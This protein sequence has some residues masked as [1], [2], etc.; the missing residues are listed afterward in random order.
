MMRI[1]REPADLREVLRGWRREGLSVA[2]VPTMGDLH[3]GHMALVEEARRRADRVIVSVFVNPLQFNDPADFSAYP[4]VPEADAGLLERAGVDLLF[5]PEAADVYPRGVAAG[6]RVL[7]PQIGDELCGAF[8]PGHFD[9]VATVVAILF[10]LTGPDIALFGEKDYQQ[11]LLVRRMVADLHFPI[12]IVAVPTV[13]EE[14]GLALSSRNR[15]LDAEER[16]R[17]GRLFA[18]LTAL[19]DD[20]LRGGASVAAALEQRAMEA[21]AAAG[22]RP[23][24]V[25]IRRAADLA[26]PRA[27]DR[28][29]RVLA[30]AWLGRARLIDNLSA[31]L[32]ESPVEDSIKAPA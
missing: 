4:R 27:G 19:R 17:A 24:Y 8:R 21:L 20:L 28:H 9:G 32:P 13:R 30:A 12:D 15:Y 5:M 22:F 6:A 3:A 31:D 23:E 2:L 11:L 25:S 18:A 29:L 16:R 26:P 7:V 10:N 14:D 1:V